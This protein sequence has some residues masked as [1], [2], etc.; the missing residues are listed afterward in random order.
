MVAAPGAEPSLQLL[1]LHCRG[2]GEGRDV[3]G[4]PAVG[5]A[6]EAE[7]VGPQVGAV[8]GQGAQQRSPAAVATPAGGVGRAGHGDR[9]HPQTT[10]D[11]A[12]GAGWA[13]VEVQRHAA[14]GGATGA[15]NMGWGVGEL[16][17]DLEGPL[18]AAIG[19]LGG[20]DV[21]P[22]WSRRGRGGGARAAGGQHASDHHDRSRRGEVHPQQTP[23][24]PLSSSGMPVTVRPGHYRI[25]DTPA[26]GL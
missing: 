3:R 19:Q 23:D 26:T 16:P 15:V 14:N 25:Q 8:T 4:E 9:P 7:A 13:L 5:D 18:P 6:E 21:G 11:T 17:I 12:V 1:D 22:G 10:A 20:H 24:A 2:H